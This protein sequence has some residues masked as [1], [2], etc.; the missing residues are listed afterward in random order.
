MKADFDIA[1]S[2]YD[3]IFT[4]SNI[5]KAQRNR[6]Y[7]HITP[8][9]KQKKKLSILELN[10][11]TGE[12]AIQF[13]NLGHNVIATD[14]SKGMIEIANNKPHPK[15]VSFSTLDINLISKASFSNKFDIIFSNFGGLNCLSKEQLNTFLKESINLLN[16]NG[17]LILVIMPKNCLWERLYFSLKGNLKKA[18]RRNTTK[19]V[20][21]NVDGVG[22]E[23]WYY[24]A[25]DIVSLTNGLY[26]LKTVKPIGLAIPPSYLENSILA[27]KPL[28]SIF[29]GIDALFTGAFWAKYADHFLIELTKNEQQI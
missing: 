15:N 13:G 4:F 6:V 27:K 8:L 28:L 21:A 12:D 19:S 20:I 16:T 23:T 24:N 25:E 2:Q 1:S 9:L 7:K 5:G 29:K 3:T 11:G 22:I 26:T 10:C 14:I 18:K 17:K